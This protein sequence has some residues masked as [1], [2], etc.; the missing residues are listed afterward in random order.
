MRCDNRDPQ[1]DEWP[2]CR[3][4]GRPS[5]CFHDDGTICDAH[6]ECDAIITEASRPFIIP[7]GVSSR[8]ASDWRLAQVMA[9]R[10]A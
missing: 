5:M 3:I 4:C 10:N 2:E 9:A 1:H 8:E 6:A 7:P